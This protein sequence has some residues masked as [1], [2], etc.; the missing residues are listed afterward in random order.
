MQFKLLI[1]SAFFAASA[2][3]I[4]GKLGDAAIIT[5]NPAG[6]SYVA[7]LPSNGTVTGSAKFSSTGN[8]T[9][10]EVSIDFKGFKGATGPYTYHV[11]DQPVPDSGN[12]NGTLAHLDPYQ[13]GQVD[14]CD[15]KYP[16]T[17]EVGDLAGKHG[18]IPN[19]NGSTLEV[20]LVFVDNYIST[21]RG[22]GAFVGNRSIVIHNSA[23][24]RIACANLTAVGVK[25]P[26]APSPNGG[27]PIS[28]SSGASAI[29]VSGLFGLAAF[30]VAVFA[31]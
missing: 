11:H 26:S 5:D 15:P 14:P 20:Y 22:I 2:S 24:G 9:G 25:S 13:R 18:K 28:P 12:C 4:T 21:K 3:A 30:M 8:G 6:A 23:G 16:A 27:G 1:A 17:C 10:V 7:T 31:L 19:S 29:T